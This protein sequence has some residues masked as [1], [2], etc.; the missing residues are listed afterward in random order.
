MKSKWI[1]AEGQ[2]LDKGADVYL[3]GNTVRHFSGFLSVALSVPR[4]ESRRINP[5]R[6]VVDASIRESKSNESQSLRSP[7]L[8]LGLRAGTNR[9]DHSADLSRDRQG[10]FV[11]SS[12]PDLS[13]KNASQRCLWGS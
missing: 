1:L 6:L 5:L 11:L 2:A 4:Q 12:W 9:N 8:Q 13:L 3:S 10:Y 7:S